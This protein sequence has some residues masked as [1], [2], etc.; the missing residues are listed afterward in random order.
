[1]TQAAVLIEASTPALSLLEDE[2]SAERLAPGG[3][4][5]ARKHWD[6]ALGD[7]LRDFLSRPGKEFRAELTRASWTLGVDNV[8]DRR[9]WR[10][11]PY[12]FGHIYLYQGAPRTVRIALTAAL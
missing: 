8:F 6:V 5:I 1:M 12:Q 7:P 10:E 3:D 4:A 2:L 9:F 11:S